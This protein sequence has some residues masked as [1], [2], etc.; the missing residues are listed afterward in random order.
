MK[1][2][3]PKSVAFC[4]IVTIMTITCGANIQAQKAVMSSGGEAAGSNGTVSY[5]IGQLFYTTNNG[6][7]GSVAEG[8]QQAYEISQV[9]LLEKVKLTSLKCTVYPNPTSD[10]LQLKV[11]TEEVQDLC[12]QLFDMKGNL[13]QSEKLIANESSIKMENQTPAT[14]FLK[15]IDNSTGTW[16]CISTFKIIKK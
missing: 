3:K 12:Y 7:N 5:S 14:Y 6:S 1:E 16:L 9:T 10:F 13:I 4:L 2:I 8:V 11:E 15:V